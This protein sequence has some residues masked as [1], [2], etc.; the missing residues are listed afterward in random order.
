MRSDG[1]FTKKLSGGLPEASQMNK[2]SVTDARSVTGEK[3]KFQRNKNGVQD[4][5]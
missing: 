5:P 3:E 4:S 2:T 1:I